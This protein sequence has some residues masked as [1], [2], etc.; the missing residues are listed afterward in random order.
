MSKYVK[1]WGGE[2]GVAKQANKK[3][4]EQLE[5]ASQQ[6]LSYT[7]ANEDYQRCSEEG[8]QEA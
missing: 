3:R 1:K 2:R 5:S 4:R 8:R 6:V 7:L